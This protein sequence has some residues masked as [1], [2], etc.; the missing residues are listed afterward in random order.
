MDFKMNKT[1]VIGIAAGC[2]V[3]IGLGAFGLMQEYSGVRG[4]TSITSYIPWGLYIALFLFF[5]AIGAGALLLAA[6]GKTGELPRIKLAVVG[7]VCSACAGLAI[8]PDL[9]RPLGMWRLFFAPNPASPLLLDVWLLSATLVFGVLL[10]AGLRFGK[11]ALARVGS[12]G[13]AVFA[14]LLPLGTAVMFCSIPGKL[15]WESPAEIAIAMVHV[16][17]AGAAVALLAK[18]LADR[19]SNNMEKIA[20]AMIVANIVLVAGEAMLLAYRNDF[21]LKAMEVVMFGTFA[22]LFWAQMI[23]GLVVPGVML[24]LRKMPT[25]AAGLALLG[26]LLGKYTYVVRGSVYPTY[27][28]MSEGIFV[29]TLQQMQGPQMIPTYIPTMNEF[30]VGGAVVAIAVLVLTLAYNSKLVPADETAA[31]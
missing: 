10:I 11:A 15:G 5:E 20:L 21:A 22:P 6:L 29:P 18:G 17:M 28:E 12:I 27:G 24:A 2:L 9:G 16:V 23:V 19:T 1:A 14:V 26:I 30:F 8:L 4:A 3:L 25:I 13:S 31:K 7:V